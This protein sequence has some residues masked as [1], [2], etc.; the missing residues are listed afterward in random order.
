LFEPLEILRQMPRDF[1]ARANHA[2][3]RH[4]GDGFEVFHVGVQASAC[5]PLEFKLLFASSFSFLPPPEQ[6]KA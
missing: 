3:Q 4:C 2:V 6:A 5:F 1:A